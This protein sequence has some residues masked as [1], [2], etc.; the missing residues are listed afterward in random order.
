MKGRE[1]WQLGS[2]F[3]ICNNSARWSSFNFVCNANFVDIQWIFTLWNLQP[4][5]GLLDDGL[6]ILN[7]KNTKRIKIANLINSRHFVTGAIWWH[8]HLWPRDWKRETEFP[9][10]SGALVK[11]ASSGGRMAQLLIKHLTG[12]TFLVFYMFRGISNG[13][14]PYVKMFTNESSWCYFIRPPSP[15]GSRIERRLSS[16]I[17]W[18]RI[19]EK[20]IWFLIQSSM[21]TNITKRTPKD[22]RLSVR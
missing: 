9:W 17:N 14:S 21:K 1:V 5:D 16:E 13:E 12:L 6:L 22:S 8:W 4:D 10:A 2:V 20:F 15:P 3:A 18:S 19:Y 7:V 11:S